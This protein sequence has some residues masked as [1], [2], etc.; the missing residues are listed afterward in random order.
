MTPH[1]LSP[2]CVALSPEIVLSPNSKAKLPS[3]KI[4]TRM[5]SLKNRTTVADIAQLIEC[6]PSMPEAMSLIPAL[7]RLETT[8]QNKNKKKEITP[9]VCCRQHNI[10]NNKS[11]NIFFPDRPVDICSRGIS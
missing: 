5:R 3:K 2:L 8:K 10:V 6:L 11:T 7:G 1:H 4:Q 9:V